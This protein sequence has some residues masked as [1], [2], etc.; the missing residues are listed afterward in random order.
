MGRQT[1]ERNGEEEKRK[2][3]QRTR[4]AR[5]NEKKGKKVDRKE[6]ILRKER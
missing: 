6:M 2:E 5:G 4:E 3:T 1:V